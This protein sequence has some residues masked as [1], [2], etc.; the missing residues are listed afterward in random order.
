MNEVIVESPSATLVKL[1]EIVNLEDS[2]R[3]KR[4]HKTK[5]AEKPGKDQSDSAAALMHESKKGKKKIFCGPYCAPGKHTPEVTSHNTK[6]CWQEHPE[7]RP[8]SGSKSSSLGFSRAINQ[9]VRADD[10]HESV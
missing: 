8:M 7:L 6:H 5:P 4:S 1:Q 3:S 2:R 9:L 10:G